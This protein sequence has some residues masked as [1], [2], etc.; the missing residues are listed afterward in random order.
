MFRSLNWKLVRK[1]AERGDHVLGDPVTKKVLAGIARQ[2]LER[3][4]GH[5]WAT[6]EASRRG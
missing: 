5:G 4:D 6:R 3:Q 1:A 2:V